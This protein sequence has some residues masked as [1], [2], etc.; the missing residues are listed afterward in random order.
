MRVFQPIISFR[1]YKMEEQENSDFYT[2]MKNVMTKTLESIESRY[3]DKANNPEYI[4]TGFCNIEFHKGDLIVLAARSS[5]GKTAFALSLVNQIAIIKKISAGYISL[6][7]T[8]ETLFGRRLISINSGIP[9]VKVHTGMLKISDV[10]KIRNSA[11]EICEAPIYLINEPNSSFN[12]LEWKAE[13]MI[14]E[15]Q[16]QL[17]FIN[18]LGLFEELVDS[19]KKEYRYNLKVLLEKLKK[20]A[21]EHRIPVILEVDLPAAEQ[22]E[23]PSLRDFKK[24]M[25]IP[26]MA[27]MVLLIHRDK[28]KNELDIQE[29][30]L[31]I[32]KNLTGWAAPDIP[33]T[34]N[35]KTVAFYKRDSE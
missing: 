26:Y 21:V 34:F 1:G 10:E 33:L 31:N 16:V 2:T 30:T 32:E 22:G 28:L 3:Q 27:D 8:E 15:K 20:F 35:P 14:E 13:T 17:I 18:H 12:L 19:N 11:K 24:H 9:L 4:D 7:S 29:A 25:I 5:V 23:E 6:E